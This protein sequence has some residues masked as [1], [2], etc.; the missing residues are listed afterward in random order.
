MKRYVLF[1]LCLI[2][3]QMMMAQLSGVVL[4]KG[5]PK[6]GIV[7]WLK[8]ADKSVLT[9]KEGRFSFNSASPVDTLQI[10]AFTR[11]DAKF[12]V[13]SLHE[14]T[15]ALNDDNFTVTDSGVEQTLPYERVANAG[16]GGG[17]NHE[18]IMR[19]G[20]RTVSEILKNYVPGVMVQQTQSGSSITIRGINSINSGTDPLFVI[21]GMAYQTSDVDAIIPVETIEKIEVNKDGAGWGVR[22]A[23]GVIIITTIQGRNSV[24]D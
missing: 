23:N 9:D 12:P 17:V 20:M 19:S 18:L 16:G 4:K 5:K 1:I 7:V 2:A 22:G 15:I 14:M 10:A 11:L 8:G 3:S 24:M 13:G 6:K 21:D